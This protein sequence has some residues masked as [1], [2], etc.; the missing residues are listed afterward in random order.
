MARAASVDSIE[1]FRFQVELEPL[2]GSPITR[3]GFATVSLPSE[4]NGEVL[5]REGNYRDT[6]EK[7]PGLTVYSD[8]ELGRGATSSQ[9]FYNWA[10]TIKKHSP[11]VRPSGDA[12]YT[13]S[14]E[15]PSDDASNDFRRV[16]RITLLDREGNGVKR[17]TCYNCHVSDFTPGDGLDANAEEKLMESLTVRIEG[18]EEEDLTA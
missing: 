17:W 5:Y 2:D 8:I 9:D 14:D 1:K 16:L 3:A 10:S 6:H 12:G 18:Y 7:S 11:T 13:S 15:R 4:S